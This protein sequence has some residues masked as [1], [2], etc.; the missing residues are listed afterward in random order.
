MALTTF[1]R[2]VVWGRPPVLAF[3]RRGEMTSHSAS[4]TSLGYPILDILARYAGTFETP[5][6]TQPRGLGSSSSGPPPAS[7]SKTIEF[8]C[9]DSSVQP[10]Y[11]Q[12]S[13]GSGKQ[14]GG[15]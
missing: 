14:A 15:L 4:L 2:E 1:R 7:V 10:R 9:L 3:G 8:I 6:K 12:V 11:C 13:S 5:S